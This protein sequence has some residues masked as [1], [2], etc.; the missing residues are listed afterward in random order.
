MMCRVRPRAAAPCLSALQSCPV[1]IKYIAKVLKDTTA[2]P[3]G[4]KRPFYDYLIASLRHKSDMVMFQ[5]ARTIAELKDVSVRELAPAITVL[6]L[7]LSSARP[8]VRF[9][10]VRI[11]NA[12]SVSHPTAVTSCNMELEQLM[13]DTNRSIAVYAI[14]TL[15]KTGSESSVERLLKQIRTFMS[16]IADD[17]KVVV[18]QAIK[19]LC[20]K[21]PRKHRVLLNFLS[22]M[23]R[24]E[25]GPEF[26]RAIV[27]SVVTLMQQIEEAKEP[28][29]LH[30]AEFIEDCEFTTL[31]VQVRA[32][33]PRSRRPVAECG[34][35]CAGC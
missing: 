4:E 32:W 8:V 29:L 21:Y 11:L 31:A 23:L 35:L 1:Q 12:V 13:L 2:P 33:W 20:L 18:V 19:A 27:E 25:G 9:A 17:F 28:G 24:E 14:T 7:F 22:H 15:L 3:E 30:L 10:A 6:H 5:A 26:K 34:L 16:D